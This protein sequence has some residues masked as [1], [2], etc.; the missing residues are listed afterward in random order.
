MLVNELRRRI[1]RFI[2]IYLYFYLKFRRGGCT[3][4]RHLKTSSIDLKEIKSILNGAT[5]VRVCVCV[6]D[7]DSNSSDNDYNWT[8]LYAPKA[9][10]VRFHRALEINLRYD[11]AR[12]RQ[13]R[14]R[15]RSVACVGCRGGSVTT[16]HPLRPWL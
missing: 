8:H 9:A 2:F 12:R 13:A 7:N 3:H 15:V 10:A 16:V 1:Y 4:R 11:Y 14:A 5:A 6:S